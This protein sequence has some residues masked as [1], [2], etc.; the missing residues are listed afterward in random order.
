MKDRGHEAA[1]LA[2]RPV[3]NGQASDAFRLAAQLIGPGLVMVAATSAAHLE[4]SC[5]KRNAEP[6]AIHRFRSP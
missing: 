4:K 5:P 1:G 3:P 6:L 2:T